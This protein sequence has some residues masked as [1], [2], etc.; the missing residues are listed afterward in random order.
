MKKSLFLL[1][2]FT[3]FAVDTIQNV[4][5]NTPITSVSST[6]PSVD[7]TDTKCS[8]TN[9][10]KKECILRLEAT[11]IGIAPISALSVPQARAMARRAAVLDAYKALVE[12]MYGIKINGRDSVKN[13]ILQNSSLRGY[14]EGVI[15][16]A[17]IEEEEFKDGTYSVIMSVKLNV[18]E[19]NRFLQTGR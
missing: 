6:K 18:Q 13:M 10:T 5:T 2:P 17:K 19:W 1:L 4:S 3:L 14:V 16:G 15:R 9:L 12:K 8:I 7:T 11:G